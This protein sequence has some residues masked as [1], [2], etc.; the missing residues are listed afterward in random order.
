MT[1]TGKAGAAF[2]GHA[3]GKATGPVVV[4]LRLRSAAGG[5]GK[6]E[7]LGD[8]TAGAEPKSVAFNVPAGD[9]QEVSV[10]VPAEGLLGTTRLYLPTNAPLEL[11]WAE[12]RGKGA[13]ARPQRWDF[14]AK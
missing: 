14:N 3:M 5:A 9:W 13:G 4:K 1:G 6:V 8:A 10:Q 11:D 2:L 12:I 7:W